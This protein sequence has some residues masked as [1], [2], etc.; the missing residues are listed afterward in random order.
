[1]SEEFSPRRIEKGGEGR[2]VFKVVGVERRTGAD[3]LIS[4]FRLIHIQRP[5][6]D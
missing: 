2:E 5:A 1:M 3:F 6:F 4:F